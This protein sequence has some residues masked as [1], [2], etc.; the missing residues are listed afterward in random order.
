MWLMDVTLIFNNKMW[1]AAVFLNIE[2]AFDTMWHSGLLYKLS[3]LE[4]CASVNKLIPSFLINRKIKM[5]VEGE[6]STPREI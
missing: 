3:E 1:M 5:S 4:F 2:K 6:L